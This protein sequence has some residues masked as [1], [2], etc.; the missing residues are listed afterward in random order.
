M[1]IEKITLKKH[2]F[3]CYALEA[4]GVPQEREAFFQID[5]DIVAVAENAG[6]KGGFERTPNDWTELPQEERGAYSSG[7]YD[8]LDDREG[9]E[10]DVGIFDAYFM[11]EDRGWR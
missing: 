4:P 11:E 10:L 7:A 8:Y 9:E 6:Y 1:A 2:P 5:Y 3:G